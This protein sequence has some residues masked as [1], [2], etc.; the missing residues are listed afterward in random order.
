MILGMSIPA[1][2]AVHTAISL[3][4]I[5]T[6][7][8]VTYGLLKGKRLDSWTA[9]FLITTILTSITGFFFPFTKFGPPHYVGMISLVVLLLAVLAR[10]TFKLA[11]KSRWVYAISAIVSLY[12]NVFVGVVQAFQ[13][14]D[15]LHSLAPTQTEPP[16]VAAQGAVF[17]IFVLL[18]VLA[19]MRFKPLGAV[20]TA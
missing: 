10:Y 15:A 14:I 9:L 3:I 16:F 17:A 13:K 8:V 2:T 12:L 18:G 4:G 1:F 7:V 19:T 5:V 11:G 20:R 6:G